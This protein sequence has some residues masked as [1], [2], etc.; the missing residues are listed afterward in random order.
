LHN[1]VAEELDLYAEACILKPTI[2]PE[3]H[4]HHYPLI[5]TRRVQRQQVQHRRIC[6]TVQT[7][8]FDAALANP[9]S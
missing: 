4:G 6:I 3:I 1:F 2:L 5:C 8:N 7:R 9:Q